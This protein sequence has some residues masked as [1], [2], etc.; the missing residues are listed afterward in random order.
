MGGV[1][2]PRRRGRLRASRRDAG[3]PADDV[4][5]MELGAKYLEDDLLISDVRAA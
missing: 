2:P 5:L 4:E 3:A 1:P